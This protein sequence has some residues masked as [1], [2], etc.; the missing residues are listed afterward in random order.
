MYDEIVTLLENKKVNPEYYKISFRSRRLARNV[1]PGQFVHIQVAKSQDPF[2]RRPFSYYRVQGERIDILYEVLG[3][4]T[5]VL[6]EAKKGARLQVMGPLGQ[7]FSQKIGARKRILVGGGVGVPPLVF[8]AERYGCHRFFIGTKS[9]KEVLP[10]AEIQK[11]RRQVFYTTEDGS[12]GV[13]GLVTKLVEECLE[14][15]AGNP[16]DYFIQTCGP[17][18]MMERVMEVAAHYGVEGEA[19]W[20]ERMACGVGVCLGCMVRTRQGWTPSCTEGP[21]FRFDEMAEK[22]G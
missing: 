12:Y 15:G 2:L 21:V 19:S 16:R 10:P 6:A 3:R 14:E 13:K 22:N 20:D 5:Q 8:L 18:R 11:F 4:G 9:R 17:N 7:E 1:R